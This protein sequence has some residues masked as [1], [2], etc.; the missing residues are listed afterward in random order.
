MTPR[1]NFDHTVRLSP[2]EREAIFA[3]VERELGRPLTSSD[4]IRVEIE[5]DK[6]LTST[7]Y[8]SRSA[9]AAFHPDLEKALM[10]RLP[11]IDQINFRLADFFLAWLAIGA[12]PNQKKYPLPIFGIVLI[13]AAIWVRMKWSGVDG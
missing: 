4:R 13:A 8:G 7:E 1:T 12:K 10:K 9:P 5:A 6:I 2:H 11:L 3:A